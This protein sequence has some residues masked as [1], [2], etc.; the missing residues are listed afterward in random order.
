[1][2]GY[3]HLWRSN[4]QRLHGVAYDVLMTYIW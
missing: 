4:V 3:G 1:M 2:S